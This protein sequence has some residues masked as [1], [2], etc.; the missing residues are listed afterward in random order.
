[1]EYHWKVALGVSK[2]RK[3]DL[4]EGLKFAD[5]AI[6]ISLNE[7]LNPQDS[8]VV[9]AFLLMSSKDYESAIEYA[10]KAKRLI[11]NNPEAWGGVGVIFFFCNE[12]Q[13]AIEAF[14]FQSKLVMEQQLIFK[15]ILACHIFFQ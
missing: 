7:K 14:E 5:E 6:Q 9:I 3:E 15:D 11:V 1:M 8:Y 12:F 2:N 10:E 4:S 13:Q